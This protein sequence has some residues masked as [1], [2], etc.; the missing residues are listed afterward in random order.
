MANK[1]VR[2]KRKKKKLVRLVTVRKKCYTATKAY[3]HVFM[4]YLKIHRPGIPLRPIASFVSSPTYA[5]SGYLARIL[6]PVVGNTD[7]TVKNV[8]EFADFI[9]DNTLNACE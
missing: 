8:C 1:V 9:R 3:V 6:L 2:K 7:Y 5:I 4:A